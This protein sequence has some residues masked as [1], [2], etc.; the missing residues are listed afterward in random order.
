[1]LQRQEY[2]Y[3][4]KI[5]LPPSC[6]QQLVS[7]HHFGD[8]PLLFRLSNRQQP[9]AAVHC[10]VLEFIA[11]ERKMYLPEWMFGALRVKAGDFANIE[12]CFLP[13]GTF[14]KIEPQSVDFLQLYDP[15]SALEE[16]LGMFSTLTEGTTVTVLMEGSQ[17]DIRILKLS[18]HT[19]NEES[20]SSA[21]SQSSSLQD[22]ER[23]LDSS[24]S[25]SNSRGG[26]FGVSIHETDLKVDFAPPVGY[27]EPPPPSVCA[28]QRQSNSEK[29]IGGFVERAIEEARK[30]TTTQSK[31][32]IV[33]VKLPVGKLYIPQKAIE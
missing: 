5:L 8:S 19:E 22:E 4:G 20:S 30:T 18:C 14:V 2:N 21:I 12:Q 7:E 17:F 16:A 3:G 15:K 33:P 23:N 27:V 6:L 31:D 29:R 10:G 11:D 24:F 25:S 1:M 26:P 32:A 13:K 9:Q 28:P